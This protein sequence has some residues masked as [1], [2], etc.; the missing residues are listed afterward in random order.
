MMETVSTATPA[1]ASAESRTRWPTGS[2]RLSDE[3]LAR[4]A[5]RGSP[6]AFAAVYERYHQ[7][8]YRYCRSIVR[9]DLDAQ[10]ALQSTFAGA[11]SA[12][13]RGQ[14]NA[15]LRPWLFRIAHNEAISVIRRRSRESELDLADGRLVTASSAEDVVAERAH[16]RQL[17]ADLADLPER[18]RAALL[19]R[20]LSG[21]PHDEIALA[22][23][24]TVGGAKQAIFEARR[25]LAEFAEGREMDC[26]IV[27]RRLSDGDGRVL[28]GRRIR[29]HL[30]DCVACEAFAAAIPARTAELRGV[31]PMLPPAAAATVLARATGTVAGHGA[32]ASASTVCTAATAGAIGKAAGGAAAWKALASALVL[33]TATAGVAGLATVLP[34]HRVPATAGARA[35]VINDAG[36]PSSRA[37]TGAIGTGVPRGAGTGAAER[38]HVRR[39]V[40]VSGAGPI[41]HKRA[42]IVRRALARLDKTLSDAGRSAHR[43]RVVGERRRSASRSHAARAHAKDHPRASIHVRKR[44]ARAQVRH[45]R[46][47]SH[48]RASPARRA[49]RLTSSTGSPGPVGEGRSHKPATAAP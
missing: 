37:R 34:H 11:L 7:P 15:P 31:V 12:L 13:K 1:A 10:D 49:K 5:A 30:R 36:V 42:L 43:D 9:D 17:S 28:R 3:L 35:D 27:R 24:T 8:L 16:M 6:R 23:G 32:G 48:K 4:Y 18:L 44:A 33:A 22:L 39:A 47:P 40:R 45:A 26:E 38:D 21:L 19:M 25:A 2:T 29:A 20:E 46:A 14:R 41:A